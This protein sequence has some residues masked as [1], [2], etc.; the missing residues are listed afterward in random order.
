[1]GHY[2]DGLLATRR[3][4]ELAE[5]GDHVFRGARGLD[6]LVDRGDVAARVDVE[7]PALR[8]G[9]RRIEYAVRGC[10]GSIPNLLKVSLDKSIATL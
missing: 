7:R 2:S 6:R 10:G 4:A 8:E 1:V 5:L 3:D 9:A